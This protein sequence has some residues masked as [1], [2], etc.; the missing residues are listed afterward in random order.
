M[1]GAELPSAPDVRLVDAI[2]QAAQAGRDAVAPLVQMLPAVARGPAS[3]AVDL[4]ART[5]VAHL[6]VFI[7]GSGRVDATSTAPMKIDVR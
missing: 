4:L 5:I 7:G 3:L 6:L 2:H 1:S